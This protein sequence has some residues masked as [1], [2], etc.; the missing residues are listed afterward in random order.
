VGRSPIAARLAASR[1]VERLAA[2]VGG[3]RF[4]RALRQLLDASEA[5]MRAVIGRIPDGAMNSKT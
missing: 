4:G 1:R 3:E 5:G 2:K